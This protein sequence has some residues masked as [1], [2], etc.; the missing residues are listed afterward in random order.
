MHCEDEIKSLKTT[1]QCLRLSSL[2]YKY[3]NDY[4]WG[5]E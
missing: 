4:R 5:Y 1:K 3:L 2:E